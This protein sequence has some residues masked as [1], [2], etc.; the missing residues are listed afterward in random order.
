MLMTSGKKAQ[1]TYRPPTWTRVSVPP[2][3]QRWGEHPAFA[4]G[5]ALSPL[6]LRKTSA[7][8]C[9]LPF[10]PRGFSGGRSQD[11]TNCALVTVV[12]KQGGETTLGLSEPQRTGNAEYRPCLQAR[13]G[14][15]CVPNGV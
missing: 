13:P 9:C 10:L 4:Q 12:S 15:A 7:K 6:V 8:P 3:W 5:D 14:R 2:P 1:G 11:P